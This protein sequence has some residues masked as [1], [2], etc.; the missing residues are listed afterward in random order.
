MI[1]VNGEVINVEKFPD[2]TQRIMDFKSSL[3]DDNENAYFNIVWLYETDAEMFTLMCVVN[4]IRDNHWYGSNAMIHLTMPYI[5]NARMDRVHSQKEVFTLKHFAN[6]INSL[7]FDKVKVFDAHSN[8]SLAVINRIVTI[9]YVDSL[10]RNSVMR[11]IND[12]NLIIYFPDAGAYKRYKNLSSIEHST[13][14][15]GEKVRDWQTGKI[16][17]IDI[18]NENND[19]ITPSDIS[20]KSVLMIDDIISYGGTMAYSADR[21]EEL[22]ADKIYAYASHTENSVLDQEKGTFLKRLDYGTIDK[23]YTTNSIYNGNHKDIKV[24][25]EF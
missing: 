22:G 20:G 7:K 24:I 11:D 5:P 18:H 1:K 8:V 4:H 16:L 14:L 2:G 21:L 17:R 13:K 9:D 15:Y 19:I 10:I 6:F 23:L 12:K 25:Y 3:F